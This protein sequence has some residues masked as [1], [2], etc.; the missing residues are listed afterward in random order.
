MS[1]ELPIRTGARSCALA[2]PIFFALLAPGCLVDLDDRCG[3]NQRYDAQQGT[4]TCQ[5]GYALVGNSCTACA[6][7]EVGSPDGCVCAEG[8]VRPTPEAVCEPLAGLGQE[9]ASDA[10]CGD[11][12][13]PHC[14]LE[15]AADAGYCTSIDCSSGEDCPTDFGC[16]SRATPSFCEMPP[17]GLGKACSSSAECEG[18]T[19]QYCETVVA[20]SCVVNDCAPDPNKCHGDW[21]CCDI[22]LLSQSLC[23]PPS[24]LEDGNC[25]AGGSLV[26]RGG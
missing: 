1:L 2:I 5:A 3:D 22:A 23:I 15:P 16:N 20:H 11:E 24:E 19:A 25:P 8:F 12:R 21:V 6:E 17:S 18:Y 14:R 26:P 7:N 9:C 4:C 10:E 13:Y